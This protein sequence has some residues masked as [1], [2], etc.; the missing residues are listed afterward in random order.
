MKYERTTPANPRAAHGYGLEIT[1]AKRRCESLDIRDSH[2]VIAA[3]KTPCQPDPI[4]LVWCRV[5][6][7]PGLT[8]FFFPILN[9]LLH[10]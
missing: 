9:V 1:P 10:A 3:E 2:L 8:L 6:E 5:V 4:Q 7:K